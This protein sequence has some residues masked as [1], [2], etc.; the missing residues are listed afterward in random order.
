MDFNKTIKF[1]RFQIYIYT[2]D[3]VP[4]RWFT[5]SLGFNLGDNDLNKKKKARKQ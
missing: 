5:F 3:G 1:W 4:S 2:F